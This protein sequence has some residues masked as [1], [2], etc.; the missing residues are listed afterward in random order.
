M[1]SPWLN[2][3]PEGEISLSYMDRL[4]MDWFSQNIKTKKKFN[5]LLNGF[6]TFLSLQV[7]LSGIKMGGNIVCTLLLPGTYDCS[8]S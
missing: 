7:F 2:S 5:F 1:P 8:F 3:D 6:T 4:M